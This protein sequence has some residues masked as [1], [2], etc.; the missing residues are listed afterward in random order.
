MSCIRRLRR[1]RS[2]G[3]EPINVGFGEHAPPPDRRVP[4]V[5]FQGGDGLDFDGVVAALSRGGSI[6][7]VVQSASRILRGYALEV[8]ASEI[9]RVQRT[10]EAT[11]GT[12]ALVSREGDTLYGEFV[13]Q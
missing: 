9:I 12:I 10:A 5:R 3:G 7:V 8:D 11:S 2:E 4:L 13:D 1:R 6:A